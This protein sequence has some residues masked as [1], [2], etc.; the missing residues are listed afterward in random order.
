MTLGPQFSGIHNPNEPFQLPL[1][2][3]GVEIMNAVT[4]SSDSVNGLDTMW[5]EK[6]EESK[7]EFTTKGHRGGH[8]SGIYDSLKE[9]GWEP[10]RNMTNSELRAGRPIH[11]G[12]VQLRHLMSDDEKSVD[13]YTS[14][15]HHRIAAAADLERQGIRT[16]YIPV[17]HRDSGDRFNSGI[18][19]P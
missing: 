18:E 9:H 17:Q 2:M 5:K 15:A 13:I 3:T 12:H 6:L 16:V 4:Q 19:K 10:T 1:F 14:N 7:R 8:G 11:N